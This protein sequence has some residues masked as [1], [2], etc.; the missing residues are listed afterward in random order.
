MLI[1]MALI[2][3]GTADRVAQAASRRDIVGVRR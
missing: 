1:L 3:V 2:V